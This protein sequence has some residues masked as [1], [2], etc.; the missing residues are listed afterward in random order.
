MPSG[1]K[2]MNFLVILTLKS[3]LSSI[4]GSS[5]YK[6][7]QSTKIGVWFQVKVD[8]F[9]EYLADKYN[10]EIAKKDAKWR[11][12]YPLLAERI[13]DLETRIKQLEKGK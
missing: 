5:F 12:D 4:I 6:W 13:E 7:F 2:G 8:T 10:I 9:M 1:E 3:I 11:T